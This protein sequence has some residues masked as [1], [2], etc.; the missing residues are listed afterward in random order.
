M[1]LT[2]TQRKAVTRELAMKYMAVGKREKGKILDDLIDLTGYNRSYASR[3]L[4]KTARTKKKTVGRGRKQATLVED[5]RMKPLKRRERPRKYDKAVLKSLKKIWI[6]YDCI[7][8]KRL[9]PYLSEAIPV[10]ERCKEIELDPEVREKLLEI[11]AASNGST[12]SRPV[13]IPNPALCSS[14]RSRSGPSVSGMRLNPALS[15][16]TW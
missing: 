8:G 6:I 13:P 2:M 15:K 7:C 5:R 14:I 12:S 3:V 10:L 9:A 11:S 16:L 1:A 4:R